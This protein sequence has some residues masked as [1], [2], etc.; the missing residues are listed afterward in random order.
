EQLESEMT[1][2]MQQLTKIHRTLYSQVKDA[3][4]GEQVNEEAP[5]VEPGDYVYVKLFKKKH[6]KEPRREG[7]FKV[8]AATSTAVKLEG[9]EHWYHLNH[10]C[11]ATG[12]G[13]GQDRPC[14]KQARP[15]TSTDSDEDNDSDKPEGPAQHTRAKTKQRET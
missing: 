12:A 7:P 3:V 15:D 2:Y 10:C 11:R 6:W 8:V 14:P 9:K 4:H 13:Q 1:S 5:L